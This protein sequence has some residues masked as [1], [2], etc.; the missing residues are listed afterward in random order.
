VVVKNG[1]LVTAELD[2][3]SPGDI[4]N[5][6]HNETK[7][8]YSLFILQDN[9]SKK[10]VQANDKTNQLVE[11]E[12]KATRFTIMGHPALNF[13]EVTAEHDQKD[14]GLPVN[15]GVS[16]APGNENQLKLVSEDVAFQFLSA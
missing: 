12:A 15:F 13:F 1:S 5:V 14:K 8:G 7:V 3:K 2:E 9:A 16:S 11:E 4:I 10:W 6:K